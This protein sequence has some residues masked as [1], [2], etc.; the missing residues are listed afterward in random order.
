MR[1]NKKRLKHCKLYL[2]LDRQVQPYDELFRILKQSVR[3]GVDI[4][5]LRD[6]TGCARD[7]IGFSKKAMQ[8]L[9]GRAA[10]V[11]NDRVDLA[12]IVDAD[13]IHVGQDD[14]PIDQVRQLVGRKMM[15]GVSCQSWAMAKKAQEAGADYLGFGSVFKTKTKPGRQPM[16]QQM[17]KRVLRD[18]NVPV[19]PIGGIALNNVQRVVDCGAKRIAVCRDIVLAKDIDRVVKE[20]KNI[21]SGI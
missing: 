2:I 19:F 16:N 9:N 1:W 3:A 7:I 6:K 21:L 8:Y 12:Q 18:I 15:V 17:L 4:V 13:G 10:F 20:Y 5:Q 11:M 14:V